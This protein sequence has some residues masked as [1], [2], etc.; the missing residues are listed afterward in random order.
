[1]NPYFSGFRVRMST[2]VRTSL[3][4]NSGFIMATTMVNGGL[5]FAYW[6]VIAR[7]SNPHEVG[8]AS[9]IVAAF[10]LT[11]L[12]ANFGVAQLMIQ[13]LPTLHDDESWSAFVT[14]G[15]VTVTVFVTCVGAIAGRILPLLSPNLAD[16]RNPGMLA[17]FAL[18]AGASTAAIGL[19]AVFV[20]SRRSDEMLY[21]NLAFSLSKGL[22][23]IAFLPLAGLIDS[24]TIVASWVA[25]LIISLVLGTWYL[26]PRIRAGHRLSFRGGV[27]PVL[28]WWRSM[29][30]HQFANLGGI[31]VPYVLPILVVIRMS[32]QA[33]A[34]FYLTWSVGAIFNM[35]SPA[36]ST[37]L[38]AEGSHGESIT[39]NVK[40]SAQLIA[41]VLGPVILIT[42]LF[43]HRILLIFGPQYAGHGSTLLVLLAFASIPDAITNIAVS[44]LR[45]RKQL[46]SAAFLNLFMA[47][48][49]VGL[50]W[51]LL[52]YYGILAP[53]IAWMAGQSAGSV[54]VGVDSLRLRRCRARDAGIPN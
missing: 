49:T 24:N 1:V 36:V 31:V 21:R 28:R 37:A 29:T 30:G 9:A 11:S 51:L 47:A 52:P 32:T 26:I 15:L 16:L 43:S 46:S 48:I 33:N 39:G 6:A 8:L 17:L 4:K 40:R 14:V 18:G 35:V 10:I 38:F 13:V 27:R 50:S 44:V 25:G 3:F 42:V 12:L 22:L 53:G 20:A 41:V 23:L 45:V 5:G 54:V 19:D 7:I 34:Y 2:A